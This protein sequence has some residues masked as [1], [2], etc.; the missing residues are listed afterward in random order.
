MTTVAA[1]SKLA[2]D[3]VAA[4]IT[5]AVISAT[6]AR[7]TQGAYDDETGSYTITTTTQTGRIVVDGTTPVTDIFP[8]YVIGPADELVMLQ[9]FTACQENDVL[10]FGG[11]D[12]VVMAVQDIAGAGTLF[13]AVVR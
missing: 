3:G 2:F 7:R 1:I 8:A 5:D 11:A 6:L 13:Y 10:T 12:R 9:G 4:K